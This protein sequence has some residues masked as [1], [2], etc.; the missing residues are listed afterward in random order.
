MSLVI[1]TMMTVSET[2]SLVT[3]PKKATAPTIAIAPG[4]TQSQYVSS[5]PDCEIRIFRVNYLSELFWGN[6]YR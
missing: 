1:S 3:P 4:S 6:V 5:S 2:V